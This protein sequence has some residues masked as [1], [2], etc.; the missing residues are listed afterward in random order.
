MAFR[1]DWL[2]TNGGFDPA[3]GAGTPARGGDDLDAFLRVV[4]DG[5][6][7]VYEPAAIVRHYHRRD[8]ASLRRQAYGY[9]VGLGA[10]LVGG[11]TPRIRATRSR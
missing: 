8:Y 6:T 9:G 11:G 4:L 1:T 5:R 10:Y 3:T 7:L 2:R